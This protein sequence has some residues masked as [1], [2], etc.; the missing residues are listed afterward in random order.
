MKFKHLRLSLC[1][2]AVMVAFISCEDDDGPRTTFQERDRGE[3]QLADK[4]SLL[5]YLASHYYNSS[6]F[7]SGSNHNFTDIEITELE[8]GETVPV[9]HSLLLDVVE[10]HTT[11]FLEAEYEYYVLR[12]NQGGGES[13]KFTDFVRVRYEGSSVINGA[14]FDAQ[15]SPQN[16]LLTGNGFNTFGSIRGW[17]LTIPMFNS[18]VSFSIDGNGIVN[19]EN[20]GLGVMFI[21]SGLGYFSGTSTGRSYDNL[22]F[23][24]ELLQFEEEDHDGDGIPSYVEDLNDDMN[25]NNDD[26]D[27]DGLPNYVDVDDDGDGVSTF[28]ELLQT[29]YSV[30]TGAGEEEPILNDNE[31]EISRSINSG[32]LTITTVT[33]LD[34]NNNGILDYLDETVSINYNEEAN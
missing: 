13:P 7:E 22:I 24:F 4:D 31:Y 16:L 12:I 32:I 27:G 5:D 30:N 6:F 34:T 14:V 11:V 23:K 19:Y 20:F 28:N 15:F 10:T 8:D 25:I 17:Q 33:A 1:I 26:T 3:Q 29:V 9:G 2:L 18:S 21:P